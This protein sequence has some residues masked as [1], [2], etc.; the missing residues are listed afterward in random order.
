MAT[1]K[2]DYEANDEEDTEDTILCVHSKQQMQRMLHWKKDCPQWVET[3]VHAVLMNSM[4]LTLFQMAQWTDLCHSFKCCMECN[5]KE[6]LS[7]AL[8]LE[9]NKILQFE[10]VSCSQ[11]LKPSSVAALDYVHL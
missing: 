3:M 9:L 10:K 1:L 6:H 2:L 11:S 4:E 7:E 5:S 8:S